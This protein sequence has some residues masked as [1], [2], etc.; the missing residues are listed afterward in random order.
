[1][2][3]VKHIFIYTLVLAF[4]Y[5]GAGV[6]I[7][8]YCC[9]QK[10]EKEM[11]MSCCNDKHDSCC[12]TKILKVDNFEKASAPTFAIPT[13][14]L[15]AEAFSPLSSQQLQS[16]NYRGDDWGYPPNAYSSRHYLSLFCVLL[17]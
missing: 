9:Q 10:Q 2:R 4:I 15:V 14:N 12:K 8:S 6:P 1:M 16:E 17:I 13:F 7:S 11:K 5:I 3:Q